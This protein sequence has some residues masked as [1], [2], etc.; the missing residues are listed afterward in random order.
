MIKSNV[1]IIDS[2]ISIEKYSDV[3][4]IGIEYLDDGFVASKQMNDAVGHGTI[5][6]SI[7][8]KYVNDDICY[9]IARSARST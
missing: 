7:I 5:I 4:G 6:Y 9:K 3:L 1:V 8:N 2:G